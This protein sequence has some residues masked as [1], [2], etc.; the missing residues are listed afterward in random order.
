MR[1][2][3]NVEDYFGVGGSAGTG[4]LYGARSSRGRTTFWKWAANGIRSDYRWRWH[5]DERQWKHVKLVPFSGGFVAMADRTLFVTYADTAELHR[6]NEGE[7]NAVDVGVRRIG[8]AHRLYDIVTTADGSM[9]VRAGSCLYYD[10]GV[11]DCSG[12]PETLYRSP[13]GVELDHLHVFDDGH[14]YFVESTPFEGGRFG[15]IR[16]LNGD[17]P[18]TVLVQDHSPSITNLAFDAQC[19]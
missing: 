11:A 3:S 5:D 12:S 10:G 15:S 17:T 1:V 18:R 14:I 4:D 13:R 9:E 7:S 19:I 8:D 16:R 6:V 2:G